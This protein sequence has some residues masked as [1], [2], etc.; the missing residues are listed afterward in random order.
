M[1]PRLQA[2]TK[3]QQE[4]LCRIA[5]EEHGNEYPCDLYGRFPWDIEL[6]GN[7]IGKHLYL[8]KASLGNFV[9]E[10]L[11]HHGDIYSFFVMSVTPRSSVF[12]RVKM[13]L[14]NREHFQANTGYILN[15]P[16]VAHL[17]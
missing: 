3:L 15:P 9:Y 11:M 10:V 8:S 5:K 12:P 17:S 2:Y 7:Q 4:E 16:P 14:E 6:R 13:S 1:K